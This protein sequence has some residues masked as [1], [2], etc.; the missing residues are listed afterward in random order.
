MK[1]VN[2]CYFLVQLNQTK[3]NKFYIVKEY[4][5][6]K[7]KLSLVK[8]RKLKIKKSYHFYK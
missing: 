1:I 2:L 5:K 3:I 6:I 8:K 7:N 4:R